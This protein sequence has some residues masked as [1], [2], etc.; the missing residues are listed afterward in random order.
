[1]KVPGNQID[2]MRR[3]VYSCPELGRNVGIG[4]ERFRAYAL[5]SRFGDW[6]HYPNGDKVRIKEEE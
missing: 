4:D 2:L 5:P 3:E 6:L 1:M